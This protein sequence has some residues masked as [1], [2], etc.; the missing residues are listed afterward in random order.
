MKLRVK[1]KTILRLSSNIAILERCNKD[2]S[3]LMKET[4]GDAKVTEEREYARMAKGEGDSIEILAR[5]KARTTLI[6]R[7][8]EQ[9]IRMRHLTSSS[10]EQLQPIVEQAA[11]QPTK[12]AIQESLSLSHSCTQSDVMENTSVR[13]PK[14]H[15]TNF[16]GNILKWPEFRDVF[17][18][19]VDKQNIR[20]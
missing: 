9:A 7:K 18:S 16:D 19:S 14:M 8:R 2:W 11:V 13:L 6:S 3:T 4:K 12:V 1:W 15:Q 5:L 17:E 20:I 10:Q